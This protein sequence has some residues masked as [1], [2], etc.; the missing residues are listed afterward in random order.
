MNSLNLQLTPLTTHRHGSSARILIFRKCPINDIMRH[1]RMHRRRA[2][3]RFICLINN[4]TSRACQWRRVARLGGNDHL[5]GDKG[6][7]GRE[8]KA[9]L[10]SFVDDECGGTG[11]SGENG[12][13]EDTVAA[14][15]LRLSSTESRHRHS[16][17]PCHKG[18]RRRDRN[19][20]PFWRGVDDIPTRALWLRRTGGRHRDGHLG[21]DEGHWGWE[22][23]DGVR[24]R[25][26]GVRDEGGC[27]G[28]GEVVGVG[29]L[30]GGDGDGDEGED[31]LVGDHFC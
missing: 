13:G 26:G 11:R 8:G 31:E 17:L 6:H 30:E 4:I 10:C 14:H 9:G 22:G 21:G 20:R 3:L 25:G 27:G 23:E 29:E 28:G 15:S 5:R 12:A 18:H 7:W 16:R 19:L 24:S 1:H 2:R